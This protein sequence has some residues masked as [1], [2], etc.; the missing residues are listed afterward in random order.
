MI[1]KAKKKVEDDKKRK[2]FFCCSSSKKVKETDRMKN[3]AFDPEKKTLIMTLEGTFTYTTIQSRYKKH[4]M[5]VIKSFKGDLTDSF[6][7]GKR[8]RDKKRSSVSTRHL[9]KIPLGLKKGKGSMNVMIRPFSIEFIRE[10]SFRYNILLITRAKKYVKK[11]FFLN[12][13]F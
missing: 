4:K 9:L 2:F 10:L 5:N 13:L 8:G 11:Y 3:N 6:N 1:E 7:N 12:N